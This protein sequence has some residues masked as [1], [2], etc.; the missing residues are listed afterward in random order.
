VRWQV[1]SL[2]LCRQ[3]FPDQSAPDLPDFA[4]AVASAEAC[5]P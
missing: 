5:K 4:T 3:L 1:L 2:A